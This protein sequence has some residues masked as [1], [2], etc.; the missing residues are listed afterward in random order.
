ME[1][2]PLHMIVAEHPTGITSKWR[3]SKDKTFAAGGVGG[4]LPNP[5]PCNTCPKTHKHYLFN[6]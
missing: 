5:C 1:L 6:C 3:K 4:A 2:S